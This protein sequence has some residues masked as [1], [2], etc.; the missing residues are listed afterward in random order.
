MG[1]RLPRVRAGARLPREAA[2]AV[3]P[4]GERVPRAFDPRAA[5]AVEPVGR[6]LQHRLQPLAE[7]DQR[8]LARAARRQVAEIARVLDRHEL[9]EHAAIRDHQHAG[10]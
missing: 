10:I 2:R 9:V 6:V 7:R 4:P 3:D 5:L 1:P 8:P